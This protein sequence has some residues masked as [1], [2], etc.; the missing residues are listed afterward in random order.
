MGMME[1]IRG[2]RRSRIEKARS[3]YLTLII[4]DDLTT[5]EAHEAQGLCELLHIDDLQVG[6]D[7]EALKE[8]RKRLDT[9]KPGLSLERAEEASQEAIADAAKA[10]SSAEKAA[11]AAQPK[12]DKMFADARALAATF[13]AKISAAVRAHDV[14][15]RRDVEISDIKL[16][17]G[18]LFGEPWPSLVEKEQGEFEALYRHYLELGRP[19]H[20]ARFVALEEIKSKRTAEAARQ[21]RGWKDA[22][23][24]DAADPR[25]EGDNGLAVEEKPIL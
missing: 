7:K 22:K 2:V 6:G 16:N 4:R 11:K 5:E 8:M 3:R 19:E 12:I 21:P 25:L 1:A 24:R 23:N 17:R 15:I 10:V 13:Q 20:I 18:Y 14:A 9:I